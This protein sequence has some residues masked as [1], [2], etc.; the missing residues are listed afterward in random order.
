[1]SPSLQGV[2]GVT[3]RV[4]GTGRG[5]GAEVTGKHGEMGAAWPGAVPVSV[6]TLHSPNPSTYRHRWGSGSWG[7][8]SPGSRGTCSSGCHP[9]RSHHW[10]TGCWSSRRYLRRRSS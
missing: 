9:H 1:M 5:M 6:P 8:T 2:E 7:L 3:A 10:H 4:G